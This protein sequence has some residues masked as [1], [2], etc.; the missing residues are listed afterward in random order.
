MATPDLDI[1]DALAL[2]SNLGFDGTEVVTRTL[3]ECGARHG[4]AGGEA[5]ILSCEWEHVE[6]EGVRRACPVGEGVVPRRKIT[7]RLVSS[8]YDGDLSFEYEK[9][10]N[11]DQLP[12]SRIGLKASLSHIQGCLTRSSDPRQT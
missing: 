12:P 11:P 9:K 4:E 10:W 2:F 7:A 8:G 5:R 3:A 1:R 6:I